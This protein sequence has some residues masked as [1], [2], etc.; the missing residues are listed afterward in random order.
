VN[1]EKIQ[2]HEMSSADKNSNDD[3]VKQRKQRRKKNWK[4]CE[5]Q[6]MNLISQHTSDTAYIEANF[7]A[8]SHDMRFYDFSWF[9]KDEKFLKFSRQLDM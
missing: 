5:T 1:Q 3:S 9:W 6:K 7:S 8:I 2:Y 4:Q